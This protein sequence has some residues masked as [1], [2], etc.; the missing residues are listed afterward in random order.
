MVFREHDL[1]HKTPMHLLD[2]MAGPVPRR[3]TPRPSGCTFDAS[4][5]LD[6]QSALCPA[7]IGRHEY[8]RLVRSFM[9]AKGGFYTDNVGV[10]IAMAKPGTRTAPAPANKARSSS[11]RL[12]TRDSLCGGLVGFH[13]SSSQQQE[14]VVNDMH[15]RGRA[16]LS[17]G[18]RVSAWLSKPILIP[19]VFEAPAHRR[20]SEAGERGRETFWSTAATITYTYISM[21][22]VRPSTGPRFCLQSQHNKGGNHEK[23]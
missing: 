23:G 8:S 2:S 19:A 9:H 14:Q 3:L 5:L 16:Q 20:R 15:A 10:G 21:E 6:Q 7:T 17:F 4:T 13:A 11:L 12:A 22:P 1:S 18:V